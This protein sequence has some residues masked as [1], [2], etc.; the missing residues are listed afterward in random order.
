MARY[1]L[2]VADRQTGAE[3]HIEIEAGTEDEAVRLAGQRGW[4]VASITRIPD[5]P[6]PPQPPPAPAPSR[7]PTPSS[8]VPLDWPV[9]RA[10]AKG[11]IMRRLGW[12]AA[13][14]FSAT[15][16][17]IT[18]IILV[19]TAAQCLVR[20]EASSKPARRMSQAAPKREPSFGVFRH[21]VRDGQGRLDKI[22][23][24][25]LC[26]EKEPII[27]TGVSYNARF[28]AFEARPLLLGD[29]EIAPILAHRT[30]RFGDTVFVWL[31]DL[32]TATIAD[33]PDEV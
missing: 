18:A 9:I 28:R 6:P 30:M 22:V 19:G 33:F 8:E 21:G 25:V 23:F 20:P 1:R 2:E 7:P 13:I 5:V 4:L 26:Y 11:R 27:V 31:D 29:F 12:Y 10:G 24:E 14:G 17:V 15:I 32:R 16:G 3:A